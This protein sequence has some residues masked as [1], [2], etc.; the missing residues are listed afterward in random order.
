[1]NEGDHHASYYPNIRQ[2]AGGIRLSRKDTSGFAR[3]HP[4]RGT[5]RINRR[6]YGENDQ[7]EVQLEVEIPYE[8][9]LFVVKV[10]R[11]AKLAGA[12]YKSIGKD[13]DVC[14]SADGHR[15]NHIHAVSIG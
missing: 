4:D 1:M 7:K 9:L 11:A 8:D 12:V 2:A 14:Q 13:E 15:E 5:R 3:R 10:P 6:D